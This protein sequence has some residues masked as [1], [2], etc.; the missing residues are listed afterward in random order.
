MFGVPSN[1]DLKHF[2][3]VECTQ[4]VLGLH[5]VQI[6]FLK[7]VSISFEGR[8]EL[9]DSNVE[10]LD[11]SKNLEQQECIPLHVIVGRL[12]VE[13]RIAAIKSIT[14]VFDNGLTLEVFDSSHEFGSFQVQPADIIV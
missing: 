7:A 1:R 11:Q 6:H 10:M 8:W 4:V 5:Q 12:V 3:G 2:T 9:R 14:S 13:T